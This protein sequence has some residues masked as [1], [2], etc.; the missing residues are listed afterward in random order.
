MEAGHEPYQSPTPPGLLELLTPEPLPL[1]DRERE[2]PG[3]QELARLGL[4][5]VEYACGAYSIALTAAGRA[6]RPEVNL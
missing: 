4:A 3:V 6:F 5:K 2:A 1:T